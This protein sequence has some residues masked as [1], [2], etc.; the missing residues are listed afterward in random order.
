MESWLVALIAAA[1]AVAGAAVSGVVAYRAARLDR[2]ARD[3]DELR[4]ALAAYGAALDRLNLR[5]EQLP[6]AHGIKENWTTRLVALWP[7]L[8][9]LMGRLSVATVGRGGMIALDEMIAATNRLLLVAPGPV[10][11]DMEHLSELI[12]RFDPAAKEWKDEWKEARAA[13]AGNSRGAVVRQRRSAFNTIR[14][15]D[16]H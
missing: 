7:I 14:K 8:D 10:L 15:V 12:G 16:S 2:E 9:W 4:A 3:K 5:I 1:G 11:D 13:F 6:Q